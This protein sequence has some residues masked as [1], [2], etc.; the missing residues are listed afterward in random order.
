MRPAGKSVRNILAKLKIH[1]NFEKCN[2]LV[3][4]ALLGSHVSEKHLLCPHKCGNENSF[5]K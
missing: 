2:S 1:C 3:S 5:T 4:L